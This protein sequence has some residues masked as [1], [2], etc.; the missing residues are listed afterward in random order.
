VKKVLMYS[1][2]G[3][4]LGFAEARKIEL[5]GR[6]LKEIGFEIFIVNRT[7]IKRKNIFG[8]GHYKGMVYYQSCLLNTPLKNRPIKIYYK[9]KS[10]L[11]EIFFFSKIKPNYAILSTKNIANLMF[12]KLLSKC[13]NTKVVL[14]YHEFPFA[15]SRKNIL[16]KANYYLFDK[17]FLKFIDGILPISDFLIDY[18]KKKKPGISFLKIPVLVDCQTFHNMSKLPNLEKYFLFVGS[19]AYYEIIEFIIDSFILVKNNVYKLY[20]ITNGNTNEINRIKEKIKLCDNSN[21]IKLFSSLDYTELVKYM[22]NSCGLLI[23]IRNNIRDI[24]RFPHKLG[25]YLASGCPV[26]TTRFGEPAKYL[27]NEYSALIATKYENK[28]FAA[29]MYYIINNPEIAEKI[30]LKGKELCFK[31]FNYTT[32]SEKLKIYLLSI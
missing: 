3:Y 14:I 20:L 17:L 11:N 30:G 18:I 6:S 2:S 22:Y 28:D 5:V 31:L 15:L 24:S 27:I 10:I 26:V 9:Y 1:N 19:A 25:E 7:G 23:P 21:R 29:K 13:F 8:I 12:Y 32:Y 16:T 4:P